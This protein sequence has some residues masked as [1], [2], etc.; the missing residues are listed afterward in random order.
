[1]ARGRRVSSLCANIHSE[2][3]K[4][5]QLAARVAS[6]PVKLQRPASGHRV[7][8][9]SFGETWP[10]ATVRIYLSEFACSIGESL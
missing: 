5:G 8:S 1:M 2:K 10:P 9:L 6:N 7:Q 3:L 4:F